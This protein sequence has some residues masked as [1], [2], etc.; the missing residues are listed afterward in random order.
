MIIAT[1]TIDK[2]CLW[3]S[4]VSFWPRIWEINLPQTQLKE[5]AVEKPSLYVF[6]SILFFIMNISSPYSPVL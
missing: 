4:F 5:K 2:I 1:E 6:L 3:L